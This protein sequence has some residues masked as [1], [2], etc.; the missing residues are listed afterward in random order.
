MVSERVHALD[1]NQ[2]R[3]DS[4]KARAKNQKVFRQN[5]YTSQK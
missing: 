3:D 1:K 5:E 2:Q 4:F